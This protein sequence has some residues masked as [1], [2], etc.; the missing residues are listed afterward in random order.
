MGMWMGRSRRAGALLLA[1]VV[2]ITCGPASGP[3][4]DVVTVVSPVTEAVSPSRVEVHQ[5]RSAA[6]GRTM[7]YAVY[8]PPGYDTATGQRYPTLYLLHGRGGTD[9]Q[10][11]QLGIARAADRM[12]SDGIIA[13][14]V[15]V[16]PEGEDGYWVDQA[17]GGPRWGTY[18]AVDLVKDIEGIFRVIGSERSRAIGGL[19]MGAHGAL[20]LALNYPHVWDTVGAHSL[21]LRRFEQAPSYFGGPTDFAQRD[22]MQLVRTKSDL[23]KSLTLWVDIGAQDEWA[24]LALQFHSELVSLGIPH[25]WHLW[26]GGHGGDYWTLHLDDYLKFYDGA[27]GRPAVRR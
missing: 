16:M 7:P 23:A 5:F 4:T 6:L 14:M 2:L 18:V 20:Q 15:I 19:S 8:L 13:P 21:V 3:K 25:E 10:W 24:T 17:N 27:L 22:P 9:E 12:I 1:A 11:L 26:P